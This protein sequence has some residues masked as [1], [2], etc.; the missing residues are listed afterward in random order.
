M[1]S[2]SS[3]HTC[4]SQQMLMLITQE[5]YCRLFL[6]DA[7]MRTSLPASEPAVFFLSFTADSSSCGPTFS[8]SPTDVV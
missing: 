6:R 3:Y 4:T 1:S 8:R 5:N 2:S 7:L